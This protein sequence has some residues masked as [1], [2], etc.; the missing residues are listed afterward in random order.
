MN[1]IKKRLRFYV[2]KVVLCSF[3]ALVSFITMTSY[4]SAVQE[5][6][7]LAI[8]E[9]TASSVNYEIT[10]SLGYENCL[11]AA[12][13]YKSGQMKEI[14]FYRCS[15][16][17]GEMIEQ[18]ETFSTG[19]DAVKVFLLDAETYSPI[20]SSVESIP[21]TH[22]Y[23]SEWTI[24][25]AATCTEPGSKSHHCIFC[26]AKADVTEIAK[27]NHDY[28]N[29]TCIQCGKEIRTVTFCDYDNRVIDTQVIDKGADAVLPQSPTRTGYLFAGWDKDHTNILESTVITAQYVSNTASNIFYIS[30]QTV[31]P[32]GTVTVS[33]RLTGA[34]HLCGFDL[35]LLYDGNALEYVSSDSELAFDVIANHVASGHY[36]RLNFG[37]KNIKTTGGD[38]IKVTFKVRDTQT[39]PT[40]ISLRPISVISIDPNDANKIINVDYAVCKG[41]IFV[42]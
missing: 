19:F 17:P 10:S 4:A 30:S 12:A 38:I 15:L 8:V 39:V 7:K 21:H 32:G 24:D 41:V 31:S 5:D 1:D 40:V 2:K 14:R 3:L 28:V 9:V 34:V 42:A 18:S 16:L 36:I 11:T 35:Q 23:S 20:C 37:S 22:S 29:E 13:V 33:L 27:T 25:K 26:D 6:A